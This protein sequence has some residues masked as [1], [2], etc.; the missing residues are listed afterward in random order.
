MMGRDSVA[1]SIGRSPIST[2]TSPMDMA[3]DARVERHFKRSTST[4]TTA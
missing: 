2:P 4:A 1:R 3:S